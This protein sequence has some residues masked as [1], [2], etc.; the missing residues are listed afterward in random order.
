MSSEIQF[1]EQEKERLENL[2]K[3]I[4]KRQSNNSLKRATALR[5]SMKQVLENVIDQQASCIKPIEV[6]NDL[7]MSKNL[8]LVSEVKRKMAKV[9]Y[10]LEKNKVVVDLTKSPSY[11]QPQ[12]NPSKVSKLS[13][14]K[15]FNQDDAKSPG[16]AFY[17]SG[18]SSLSDRPSHRFPKATRS[19]FIKVL[20]SSYSQGKI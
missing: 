2:V 12:V 13:K 19:D 11:C 4:L 15:R 10:Q 6:T 14:A 1:S 16:P 3:K 9:S 18:K 5:S 8:S 20:G 7:L 17:S